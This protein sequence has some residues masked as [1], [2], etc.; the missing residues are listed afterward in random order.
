MLFVLI[1][2]TFCLQMDQYGYLPFQVPTGNVPD[3]NSSAS[4]STTDTSESKTQYLR[5]PKPPYSY[6]GLAI[7]A[8]QLSPR[9]ELPLAEILISISKMFPFFRSSYTGWKASVRHTLS[10]YDCFVREDKLAGVWRVDLGRVQPSV[11]RRQETAMARQCN[12]AFE[13]HKE[14]RLPRVELPNETKNM[15][16]SKFDSSS[17]SSVSSSPV[18]PEIVV[19]CSPEKLDHITPSAPSIQNS[20][21]MTDSCKRQSSETTG[22]PQVDRTSASSHTAQ[23][24]AYTCT[25][26]SL[27]RSYLTTD[28][29]SKSPVWPM[30]DTY[31]PPSIIPSSNT[32][33]Q[34]SSPSSL[35]MHA[36]INAF[37]AGTG[38]DITN[39]SDRSM[40]QL[41]PMWK[42]STHQH[43]ANDE[44]SY[45]MPDLSPVWKSMN[46]PTTTKSSTCDATRREQPVISPPL[47]FADLSTPVETSTPAKKKTNTILYLP[48]RASTYDQ[49]KNLYMD[50]DL[51]GT[52][53]NQRERLD[54]D[55]TS[56]PS[57]QIQLSPAA[58]PQPISCVYQS[59]EID[60]T[61]RHRTDQSQPQLYDQQEVLQ[62]RQDVTSQS[63][64]AS[65]PQQFPSCQFQHETYGTVNAP[66]KVQKR[67][68]A[69][70]A[71]RKSAKRRK[72][73]NRQ[74]S[75]DN[76]QA[77][78]LDN[79]QRL[80]QN[81]NFISRPYC[82]SPVS[83][84]YPPTPPTPFIYPQQQPSYVN[85]SYSPMTFPGYWNAP[86]YPYHM[87]PYMPQD[88]AVTQNQYG[89]YGYQNYY[90]QSA[91]AYATQSPDMNPVD[92]SLSH[93]NNAPTSS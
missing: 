60:D 58:I 17:D 22:M 53:S 72:Q 93:W 6:Q 88:T 18:S 42:T 67:K 7:M 23:R 3:P 40:P 41:S 30:S 37:F 90:T 92:L 74:P 12:Y 71:D 83:H 57:P 68:R 80:C 28:C 91:Q 69:T 31:Q 29:Q 5:Y 54:L 39:T 38:Q 85:T 55:S 84:V 35:S 24:D 56:E 10:K 21:S 32:S 34:H 82:P 36:A 25:P 87:Y 45:F 64:T 76:S 73:N 47:V 14:L 19:D 59:P 43:R 2:N 4:E 1:K 75:Q 89:Y 48:S 66:S 26:P 65:A 27:Y 62:Q 49:L 77:N 46:Q 52:H 16:T 81:Y 33:I 11:F 15:P 44:D 78:A 79:L 86:A 9:K 50:D 70:T 8:I 63:T 13:L 20:N 51:L 61:E